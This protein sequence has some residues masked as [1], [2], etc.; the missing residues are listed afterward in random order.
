MSRETTRTP[1]KNGAKLIESSGASEKRTKKRAKTEQKKKTEK[2][3]PTST[4]RSRLLAVWSQCAR[5]ILA[6]FSRSARELLATCSPDPVV[7]SLARTHDRRTTEGVMDMKFLNTLFLGKGPTDER[8]LPLRR[9][10]C[11][12]KKKKANNRVWSI[13]KTTLQKPNFLKRQICTC[14]SL[15]I[16]RRQRCESTLNLR[17]RIKHFG[18]FR[19]KLV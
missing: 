10:N 6:V 2:Q 16:L 4:S 13:E 15:L 17:L 19:N 7:E 8:N 14:S 1:S 9:S 12:F 3:A 11:I 18:I 5:D